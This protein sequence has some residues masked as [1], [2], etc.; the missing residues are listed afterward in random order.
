MTA[1]LRVQGRIGREGSPA[2]TRLLIGGAAAGLCVA[3]FLSLSIG[4][5]GITLASL[6][7]VLAAI[8][9]RPHETDVRA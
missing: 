9:H 2:N 3:I 7:R 5:T 6:P 4:P 8:A 1:A